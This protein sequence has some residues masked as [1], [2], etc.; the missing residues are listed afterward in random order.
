MVYE[1]AVAQAAVECSDLLAAN[2]RAAR[3]RCGITQ[4]SLARRMTRLGWTWHSQTVSQVEQNQRRLYADE[5]LGLAL[6]LET[7]PM[8]LMSPPPGG[9]PVMTPNGTV[10]DPGV[11]A[12]GS[13]EELR[14]VEEYVEDLRRQMISGSSGRWR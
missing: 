2:V 1:C 6:A 7:L 5:V 3:A 10:I 4:A 14:R 13:G 12:S 8:T 9:P 11:L